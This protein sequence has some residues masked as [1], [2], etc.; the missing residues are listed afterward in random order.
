MLLLSGSDVRYIR[1]DGLGLGLTEEKLFADVLQEHRL[2]LMDGDL[3]ILYTDGVT[4]ARSDGDEYGYERLVAAAQRFRDRSAKVI[5]DEILKDI[6]L[7]VGG[8]EA[9]HD[10]LTLVVVKWK[11]IQR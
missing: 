9:H 5:M 7:F 1:P 4:E 10:D 3:G 2:Q 6:R 8:E 11:G